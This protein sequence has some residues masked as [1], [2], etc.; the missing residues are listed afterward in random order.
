MNIA[1]FIGNVLENNI[2]YKKTI[3]LALEAVGSCGFSPDNLL[4]I[5]EYISTLGEDMEFFAQCIP[6]IMKV[7][8]KNPELNSVL[9]ENI[10]G[11]KDLI[12]EISN[13]F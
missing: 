2:Y 1:I 5:R 4:K 9:R 3:A 10:L 12:P 6:R 7:F 13:L 11:L 8:R